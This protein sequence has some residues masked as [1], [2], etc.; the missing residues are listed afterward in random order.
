LSGVFVYQDMQ[1]AA[2]DTKRIL[3]EYLSDDEYWSDGNKII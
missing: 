3:D 1:Y 2:V